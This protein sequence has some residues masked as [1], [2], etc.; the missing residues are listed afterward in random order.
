MT[1]IAAMSASLI[2]LFAMPIFCECAAVLGLGLPFIVAEIF[3]LAS[4]LGAGQIVRLRCDMLIRS[5]VSA[6][7]FFPEIAA[8][9]SA[10]V[11]SEVI[12]PAELP[13]IFRILYCGAHAPKKRCSCIIS[14]EKLQ[15]S[16]ISKAKERSPYFVHAACKAGEW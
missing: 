5:R 10:L 2:F 13:A 3:A 14:S 12:D 6:L 7:L 1:L 4:A 11:F 8:A 9:K 16:N 15:I